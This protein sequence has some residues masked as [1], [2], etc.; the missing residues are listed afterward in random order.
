MHNL[1]ALEWRGLRVTETGYRIQEV[2]VVVTGPHPTPS[3]AAESSGAVQAGAAAAMSGAGAA[4]LATPEATA[5]LAA[6]PAQASGLEHCQPGDVIRAHAFMSHWTMRL[7]R[8]TL[9]TQLYIGKIRRGGAR[10]GFSAEYQVQF[11]SCSCFIASAVKGAL[12]IMALLVHAQQRAALGIL[13]ASQWMHHCHAQTACNAVQRM[14]EWLRSI[15]AQAS[16]HHQADSALAPATFVAGAILASTL[17]AAAWA[18][19]GT[20]RRQ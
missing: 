11:Q 4:A 19:R 20:I 15:E 10:V 13:C 9:P 16:K 8:E 6:S 2:L 1:S 5:T 17:A 12:V 3:P 7:W 18:V 14:Q